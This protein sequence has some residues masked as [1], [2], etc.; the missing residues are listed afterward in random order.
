MLFINKALIIESIK[1]PISDIYFLINKMGI[2]IK[3][4]PGIQYAKKFSSITSLVTNLYIFY[5]YS[6]QYKQ[7]VTSLTSLVTSLTSQACEACDKARKP[8]LWG[9]SQGLWGLY[10]LHKPGLYKPCEACGKACTS[11]VRLV[12]HVYIYIYI[13]IYIILSY[14]K[15]YN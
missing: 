7:K 13:H 1:K 5:I 3:C 12:M 6:I 8:G 15:Y 10:K 2:V 4:Q 9:L 11:L 14:N